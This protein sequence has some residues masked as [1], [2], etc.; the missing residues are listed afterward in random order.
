MFQVLRI[1][2]MKRF[3]LPKNVAKQQR[4]A[5]KAADEAPRDRHVTRST[6]RQLMAAGIQILQLGVWQSSDNTGA[7]PSNG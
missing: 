2:T 1:N 7:L 3:L 5:K 4:D 6:T